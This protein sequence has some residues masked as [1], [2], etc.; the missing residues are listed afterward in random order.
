MSSYT[1]KPTAGSTRRFPGLA[2]LAAGGGAATLE[3]GPGRQQR[4]RENRHAHCGRYG[5]LG[6][7]FYT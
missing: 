4:H 7:G 3:G 1:R 2:A 6:L 5:E